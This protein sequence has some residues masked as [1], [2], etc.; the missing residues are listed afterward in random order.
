MYALPDVVASKLITGKAPEISVHSLVPVG[1]QR[2]LE[3]AKLLGDSREWIMQTREWIIGKAHGL[4]APE[5]SWPD[6]MAV[7]RRTI[8]TSRYAE[9]FRNQNRK[10]PVQTVR[11]EFTL[12]PYVLYIGTM[13]STLMKGLAVLESLV[14][15]GKPRGASDLARELGLT[16]SNIHRTL[17]TLV[18]AGY[19]RQ[20]RHGREYECTLK[21]FELSSA[22]MKG[23]DVRQCAPAHIR[24]LADV[25]EETVHLSSL[26]G[27]EVI[28]VDKIESPQP[29]RA[30]SVV[31][32]RAPA[33]CVASG[34]AL[35]SSLDDALLTALLPEQ[36]PAFT[37]RTLPTL[38]ALQKQ[39]AQVRASGCA[40]NRG[41]WRTSVAGIAA[42][43]FDA[44]GLA[45][46][47]VGI[48]GP[49]ERVLP[50]EEA[51]Q[52][53]VL[54]TARAISAEL[55]CRAYP[56]GDSASPLA[57]TR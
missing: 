49:V 34:K 24:H 53:A 16:R 32:G 35:L 56:V 55:G 21:L 22:V 3:R 15:S 18:A 1:C 10:R 20:S 44:A 54:D 40:V 4:D 43:V 31:G 52:R 45:E 47:A 41:E 8:T 33:H 38:A 37:E 9:P 36:L 13:D 42:V 50:E 57:S 51:Y 26:D 29:I 48:S 39:L 27:A 14:R 7:T 19:V 23:V 2:D 11:V 30:Y 46:A 6:E 25:T 17:Q 28:Y 5:R 12:R